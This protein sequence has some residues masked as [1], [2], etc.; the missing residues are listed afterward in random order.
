MKIRI[1]ILTCTISIYSTLCWGQTWDLTATMTA[2]LIDNTLTISTTSEA[3]AMPDYD[4]MEAPW[5]NDNALIHSVV[6]EDHVTSIGDLTFI[7]CIFLTSVTIPNSVTSIGNYAF[8]N[9]YALP[10][11]TIPE[12]VTTLGNASFKM[13][14]GLTE[15]TIPASVLSIGKEAFIEC[16]KLE[17]IT[18]DDDNTAFSSLASVLYDKNKTTL[19]AYPES[20]SGDSFEI[21]GTVSKIE[22]GAF[23]KSSLESISIPGSVTEIGNDAF[24]LCSNL[25]SIT[26]PRS[27]TDIGEYAF[28][29]CIGLTEVTVEWDT[30]LIVI[31][32]LFDQVDLS[33]VTL[34]VPTG[35][36]PFYRDA[37][38]WKD[39][40]TIVEY[41]FSGNT[42][43]KEATL[44]AYASNGILHI[45]GLRSGSALHVYKIDGQ[46]MYKGIAKAN[47]ERIPLT[48]RGICVVVAG[49]Q[50]VKV[51][52]VN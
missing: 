46:L 48:G 23:Y 19:I 2:S 37:D 8:Y 50:K 25:T 42:A 9:C 28:K 15:I 34:Y 38:I 44:K 31:D 5:Y 18:V 16:N 36:T 12:K 43:I 47:E 21:A 17:A 41:A 32:N 24:W 51:W 22:S 6:I 29:E 11:I 10:A 27:V 20:K 49:E 52:F 1:L 26:L 33:G 13:C 14:S 35:T 30:P 45:L 3:E 7:H 39:F 40:G 4:W